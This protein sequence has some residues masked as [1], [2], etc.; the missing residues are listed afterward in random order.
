MEP[1]RRQK[2]H[3]SKFVKQ[4]CYYSI[5][6][7]LQ[8]MS[9]GILSFLNLNYFFQYKNDSDGSIGDPNWKTR[10]YQRYQRSWPQLHSL[11][12]FE[13]PGSWL[14]CLRPFYHFQHRLL[15]FASF[16]GLSQVLITSIWLHFAIGWPPE[17]QRKTGICDCWLWNQ[18]DWLFSERF[19]LLL[20]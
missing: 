3:Q 4:L 5:V 6:V 12:C 20:K 18:S 13:N 8:I 15:R 17:Y 19:W 2:S 9:V 14:G 7:C 11:H 16:S 1:E 10:H